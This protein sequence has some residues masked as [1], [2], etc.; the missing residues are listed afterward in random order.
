MS[1]VKFGQVNTQFTRNVYKIITDLVL[2]DMQRI[3]AKVAQ[4]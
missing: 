2:L 4:L 1:S 3:I